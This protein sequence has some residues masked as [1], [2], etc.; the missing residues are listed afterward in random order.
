MGKHSFNS[1]SVFIISQGEKK[2]RNVPVG[3]PFF[4]KGKTPGGCD[5]TGGFRERVWKEER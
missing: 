2:S 1:L 4:R 5:S 3:L